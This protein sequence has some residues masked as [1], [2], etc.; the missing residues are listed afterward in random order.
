MGCINDKGA[1]MTS[2]M[3]RSLHTGGVNIVFCDG[4]VHFIG[5]TI[6]QFT[7]GLLC[8]KSDGQVVPPEAFN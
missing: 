3:S 2:G 1:I 4:S 7:W 8:S 6:S 5:N